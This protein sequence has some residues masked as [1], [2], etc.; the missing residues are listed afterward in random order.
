VE[1]ELLNENSVEPALTVP[2][3]NTPI[4]IALLMLAPKG[5]AVVL[6]VSSV[7]SKAMVLR[8]LI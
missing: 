3:L 2:T 4:S 8:P 7:P 5:L 1:L 6:S